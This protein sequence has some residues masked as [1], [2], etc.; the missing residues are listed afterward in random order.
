MDSSSVHF[1]ARPEQ[2]AWTT[3]GNV[4]DGWL[5]LGP[6]SRTW[7]RVNG[8]ARASKRSSVRL[9]GPRVDLT[10]TEP[11]FSRAPEK[12][13]PVDATV[14]ILAIDVQRHEEMLAP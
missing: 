7:H 3:W 8:T 5:V 6:D 11:T 10:P 2:G 12:V 1:G 4:R 14:R 9:V 13:Y